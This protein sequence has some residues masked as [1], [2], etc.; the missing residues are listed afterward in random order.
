MDRKPDNRI[1]FKLIGQSNIIIIVLNKEYC[2]EYFN[3][4][5]GNLLSLQNSDYGKNIFNLS[6]DWSSTLKS[7]KEKI[8]PGNDKDKYYPDIKLQNED[9]TE[10][11]I[12]L[13][14]RKIEITDNDWYFSINGQDI[15][16]KRYKEKEI[17]VG[18]RLRAIGE[19]ASGI[20]HDLNSP[21]QFIS[22][23]LVFVKEICSE[24]SGD[25][26][27]EMKEAAE[28]SLKGI[29]QIKTLTSALNNFIYTTDSSV[30]E[31]HIADIINN[32]VS[33]SKNEWK[34]TASTNISIRKNIKPIKNYPADI[35]RVLINL[36]VNSAQ[37]IRH[38]GMEPGSIDISAEEIPEGIRLEITDNGPG[39]PTDIRDKIFDP[40]FT[41]K[42]RGIG[43]G[44]GLAISKSIM[45]EKCG[46]S[47]TFRENKP[48]GSIFELI[49]PDKGSDDA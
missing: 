18:E 1:L 38:S 2:I 32:A 3:R 17:L 12:G 21:L 46:G 44:Q 40:F 26:F 16:R 37:A 5:A 7:F 31:L 6:Y 49:V 14:I 11:V 24:N 13:S 29:D 47:I 41:T 10:T 33:L 27:D 42:P 30:E 35:T 8:E 19:L 15:T 23:N 39:I 28:E 45:N 4:R 43:T 34:K 48:A 9:N 20:M 36:I 22:N 25:D